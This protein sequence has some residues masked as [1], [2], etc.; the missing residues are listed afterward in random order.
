M[1]SDIARTEG[2]ENRVCESMKKD[3][4]IGVT[5][6]PPFVGNGHAT[7]DEGPSWNEWM[8]I[9]AKANAQHEWRMSW[10]WV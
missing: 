2:S 4:S 3:I 7:K 8:N 6:E 1:G 5:F 10:E 9:I